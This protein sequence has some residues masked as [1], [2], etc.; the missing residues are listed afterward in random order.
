MEVIR[1]DEF[2]DKEIKS[3]NNKS[4][5]DSIKFNVIKIVMFFVNYSSNWIWDI[6]L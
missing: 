3:Y 1:N 6:C 2:I 5:N 4:P